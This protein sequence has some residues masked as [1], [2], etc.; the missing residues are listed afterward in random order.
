MRTRIVRALESKLPHNGVALK[1]HEVILEVEPPFI[2]SQSGA[3]RSSVAGST[4]GPTPRR[5]Q[6]SAVMAEEEL[7]LPQPSG[8]L[9]MNREIAIAKPEP[10]LAAKRRESFH[11]R[12]G[13]VAPAPSELRIV[14]AGERVHQHVGVR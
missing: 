4:R 13:L 5:R 6:K 10:I 14:E 1:T 11:E 3:N 7:S 8:A 12:P 9:D 2:R